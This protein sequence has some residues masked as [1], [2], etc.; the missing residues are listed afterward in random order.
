[1]KAATKQ[2]RRGN[3]PKPGPFLQRKRN[4]APHEETPFIS[5]KHTERIQPKLNISVS[6]E[7]PVKGL[8]TPGVN[9]GG[10][11]RRELG[12]REVISRRPDSRG[13]SRKVRLNFLYPSSQI[14][15]QRE[16]AS[17][18]VDQTLA[19][20]GRA[21]EPGLRQK[22][23]QR[24]GYDF[25]HVRVHADAAAGQSAR[26]INADAYTIGHH[27]FFDTDRFAPE[28][29]EGHRLLTHELAHV[30]QQSGNTAPHLQRQ[31]RSSEAVFQQTIA[32]P[33]PLLASI[34]LL[35]VVANH[36]GGVIVYRGRYKVILRVD[37]DAISERIPFSFQFSPPSPQQVFPRRNNPIIYILVG[38]GVSIELEGFPSFYEPTPENTIPD[39][40]IIRAQS[41][42]Q[43]PPIGKPFT[44]SDYEDIKAVES[45]DERRAQ[46]VRRRFG[47]PP[48]PPDIA[49]HR[50]FDGLDIVQVS[51]KEVLRIRA[52]NLRGDTA[53]AYEVTPD[54]LIKGSRMQRVLVKLI[55]TPAVEVTL[56]TPFMDLRKSAH[57][58]VFGI[59]PIAYEV[60]SVKDVPQQ[61][62]PIP[63]KG[64]QVTVKHEMQE[65]LTRIVATTAID[66]AIGFIPVAGD[67]VDIAEFTYGIFTGYDRWGRRLSKGDLVLMGIGALLPFVGSGLLKGAARIGKALNRDAREVADLVRATQHLNHAERRSVEEWTDLIRHGRQ[68]P[69]AQANQAAAIVRKMDESIAGRVKQLSVPATEQAGKAAEKAGSRQAAREAAEGLPKGTG[70]ARVPRRADRIAEQEMTYI[71]EIT[72]GALNNDTVKLLERKPSLRHA[73]AENGLAAQVLK[74]CDS[75]CFPREA[76]PEQIY[77]LDSHL[78]GLKASGPYDQNMLREFLHRNREDLGTAIDELM[79]YETS[80]DLDNFLRTKLASVPASPPAAPPTRQLG[81]IL[82]G[83]EMSTAG[84][85]SSLQGKDFGVFRSRI[86][87]VSHDVAVKIYPR[88]HR[89]FAQDLAG[90][91]AAES[92]GFG[93]KVYGEVDVGPGRQAFAMEIVP[94]GLYDP[95][96]SLRR[97][98]DEAKYWAS[99]V[100]QDTV[101]DLDKYGKEL[102]AKGYYYNGEVQGFADDAGRW[103]PIDFQPIE[104]LPPKTSK[105]AF[106]KAMDMHKSMFDDERKV[107]DKLA[108]INAEAKKGK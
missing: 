93:P 52:P 78:E 82:I 63:D 1:M 81:K 83:E 94:G 89:K 19:G 18:S 13:N 53:Y 65:S 45:P 12:Q 105:D 6:S 98:V 88:G 16:A 68:I 44:P 72:G 34:P 71:G 96:S 92:T 35:Q 66:T 62:Q 104:K 67:L 95:A 76:T 101:T 42:S 9:S 70:K 73:L 38:P 106:K 87:D 31:A 41:L 37:P 32:E 50:R 56:H 36:T 29:P 48:L 84:W 60:D 23:E 17:S 47:L 86:P 8:S 74:K 90:A 26:Q 3:N 43:V 59:V 97:A 5:P 15:G 49:V 103:R 100:T 75:S 30:I 80:R 40:T 108:A 58:L 61:G 69:D 21:L 24:L 85:A 2:P 4:S 107:L 46:Q 102:L 11:A 64:R 39:V 25:G 22:M 99:K 57:G 20:P 33:N 55:K 28:K 7:A 51:S 27:I 14:H 54:R 10:S 91:R 77:A 79:K